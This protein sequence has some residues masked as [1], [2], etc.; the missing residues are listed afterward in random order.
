MFTE[1]KQKHIIKVSLNGENI[2]D[3]I[4]AHCIHLCI[5]LS[6]FHTSTYTIE[7]II[8]IRI[9]YTN[10]EIMTL[11][12]LAYEKYAVISAFGSSPS[13]SNFNGI[14]ALTQNFRCSLTPG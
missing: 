10:F 7:F 6:V 5:E 12:I 11:E 9:K 1:T 4:K 8:L 13:R 3:F 14:H 2:E